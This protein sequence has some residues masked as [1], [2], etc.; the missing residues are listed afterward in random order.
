LIP[1]QF[2]AHHT[3][4]CLLELIQALQWTDIFAANIELLI[5][6]LRQILFDPKVTDDQ[7]S[8]ITFQHPKYG[9]IYAYE[10]DGFG[11][12]NLMDDSNIPSLLSLPYLCPQH[13]HLNHSIYQNTR[14]F[15]LSTDNPWYFRGHVIEG[16]AILPLFSTSDNY[17]ELFQVMVDLMWAIRWLGHW[18]S[19]CVV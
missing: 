9:L 10:I 11:Q 2:F 3:L 7:A 8:L 4:H 19:L 18:P 15:V 5:S 13:I 14:R 17:V 16:R 1:S 6:Q 12:Q